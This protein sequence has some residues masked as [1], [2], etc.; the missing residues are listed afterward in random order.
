[1]GKYDHLRRRAAVRRSQASAGPRVALPM[2]YLRFG[3]IR[4]RD[5]TRT[6]S[7]S[8]AG[9]CHTTDAENVRNPIGPIQIIACVVGRTDIIVGIATSPTV[10]V[11]LRVLKLDRPVGTLVCL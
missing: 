10:P 3:A 7:D 6:V 11:S 8:L 5:Q 2:P 4:R 1:M 9:A